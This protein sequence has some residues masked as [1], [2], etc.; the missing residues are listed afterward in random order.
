MGYSFWADV[1]VALHVAYVRF[2]VFGQL[3]IFIGAWRQWAWVRNPWFRIGHL[4]A[5]SIVALEAIWGIACPLT[6]WEAEL[7]RKAGQ[8]VA[9]GSFIG[10]GLHFLIFYDFPPW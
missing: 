10:R 9:E 3:A 1:I 8:R 2:I 5:I 6:E 7:R 4:A